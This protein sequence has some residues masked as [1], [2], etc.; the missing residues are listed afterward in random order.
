MKVYIASRFQGADNKQEIEAL[1]KAVRDAGMKDFS[2]IRDVEHYKKT[3]DDPKELW[4]RAYDEIGACDALL[5]DVSDYPTGGRMVEAGIAYALRKTVI[6]V[7]RPGVKHK[8]LFDGIAQTIITYDSDKDL[9]QQLK[10]FDKERTF[11]TT[12]KS[13]LLLLLLLGGGALAYAAAQVWIPLAGMAALA[14]WLVIRQ[15]FVLVRAFDR[16]VIYVPLI[17]LWG[18]I[19]FW[20]TSLNMMVALAW[21]IVFWIVTL[22]L[23]QRAKFSL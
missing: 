14:Y 10:H 20:L 3:F 8:G 12:D 6:I 5:M 4:A 22:P 15:F 13:M 18:S 7:K 23:L 17:V 11:D 2:F 1:C 9:T 19:Y 21:A 16:V